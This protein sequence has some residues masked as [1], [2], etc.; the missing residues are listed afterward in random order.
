[1][2]GVAVLVGLAALVWWLVRPAPVPT[3]PIE[4][5]LPTAAPAPTAAPEPTPAEAV[6]HVAGAVAS[7]GLVVVDGVARVA[8]VVAEAGGPA[9]DADLDRVNL[10]ALVVDGDRVWIPRLGEPD[11]PVVVGGP[12]ASM[13]QA[14]AGPL[15]LNAATPDQLV[16]LPGVGPAT[17][18]AIV[19]ERER[20]GGFTAVDD[21]IEVTGIGPAKLAQLRELVRVAG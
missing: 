10:A 6:V 15:D 2:A 21:L 18:A 4:L 9:A 19:A 14:P 16:T 17:A 13:G 11:V 1:M 20:M 7:P 5:S 3:P 12:T 8:D